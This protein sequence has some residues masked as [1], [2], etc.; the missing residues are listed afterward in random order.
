M[1]IDANRNHLT[2]LAMDWGA[3]YLLFLDV[4]QIFPKGMLGKM[5]DILEKDSMIGAVSGMVFKKA[6]PYPPIFANYVDAT[7]A[8]IMSPVDPCISSELLSVDIIG[9]GCA[10]IPRWVIEMLP[11]PWFLYTV[12]GKNGEIGIT[13]DVYFCNKLK[14]MGL[15]IAVD[16]SIDSGH[17]INQIVNLDSWKSCRGNLTPAKNKEG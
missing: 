15:K 1:P 2:K 16:T 7:D 4:D 13:E 6:P 10:M 12:Y 11:Y 14:G 5:I 9:M 3:D 8:Q 17:I